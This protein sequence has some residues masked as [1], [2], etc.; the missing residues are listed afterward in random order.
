MFF[1][2]LFALILLTASLYA[3]ASLQQMK[4]ESRVALVIGNGHYDLSPLPFA[5]KEASRLKA[6]LR[7]QGFKVFYAEDTTK[8]ELIKLLRDF[9][10]ALERGGIA[11]FYFNGHA[12]Q[13]NN[14]NY[15][16]PL[17]TAIESDR[18]VLYE[19]VKLDAILK[20]MARAKNRL[21]I[22]LLDAAH[23]NPFSNI[24]RAK[25][26]GYARIP[27]MK[28]F[29]IF[30]SAVPGKTV[31]TR[32][33]ENSFTT[34][35]IRAAAD[36][37]TEIHDVSE[38]L[39]EIRLSRELPAPYVSLKHSGAFYFNLPD[40]LISNDERAFEMAKTVG[41]AA[42]YATFSQHYPESPFAVEAQTEIKR[43]KTEVEMAR[44]QRL[45]QAKEKARLRNK[46]EKA[47]A[48]KALKERQRHL[49]LLRAEKLAALK[50]DG[51]VPIEPEMIEIKAG[52]FT[53]GSDT[54]ES[55]RPIH[56]VTIAYPFKMGKYEV[57]NRE[58]VQYLHANGKRSALPVDWNASDRP[59]TNVSWAEART[60]AAWLSELTGKSYRLPSETEWE[61]AARSGSSSTY[62]WGD[63]A[64]HTVHYAWMKKNA[65]KI[66]HKVGTL[67]PNDFGLY[68]MYGNVWEWCEDDYLE[69]YT[70]KPNDGKA[71]IS[72]SA[73]KS[74]R[75]GSWHTPLDDLKAA[76]RGLQMSDFTGYSI[77]F[78][79]VLDEKKM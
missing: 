54:D 56:R 24:Y 60:Y 8:R 25:K 22:V 32:S 39:K 36:K 44:Q 77:G 55:A 42:A 2:I 9:S 51:I 35:F 33:S 74:M 62:G 47:A 43:I 29:D 78:R 12:I 26:A 7:E 63:D 49:A 1:R 3:S 23:P 31:Q 16:V 41:T 64:N 21:N 48:A 68:D 58:F 57:T 79:L 70:A 50:A 6:F 18:H 59:A 38:N 34:A 46:Q 45:A 19:A 65:D 75:G 28:G 4:Q 30:L 11:L 14:K 61:Y 66:T 72:G 10:Q 73:I 15:L 5:K 20:K 17:E 52:T 67:L 13:V 76:H 53:M 37:G 40:R 69:N 27:D 71:Y